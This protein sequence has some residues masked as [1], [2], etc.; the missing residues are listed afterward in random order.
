MTQA[1]SDGMDMTLVLWK[2]NNVVTTGSTVYRFRPVGPVGRYSKDA[3]DRIQVQRLFAIRKYN[4]SMDGTDRQDQY[5]N[6]YR[7]T[8]SGKKW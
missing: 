6:N 4:E 7:A 8:M 5:V 2:D 3:G 1:T